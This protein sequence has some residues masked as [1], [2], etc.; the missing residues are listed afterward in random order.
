MKP[1][2]QKIVAKLSDQKSK[3]GLNKV[4]LSKLN[5]I[6]EAISRGMYLVEDAFEEAY[7]EAREK[8]TLANDILRFDAND[9][10]TEADD[11]LEDLLQEVKELGIDIPPKVKAL[12]KE[13]QDLGSKISDAEMKVRNI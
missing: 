5:D 1:S 7:S 8:A 4:A 10:F 2:V 13:L 6:D 3:K 11:L 9:A 12:Q